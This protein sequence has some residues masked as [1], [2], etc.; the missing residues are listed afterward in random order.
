VRIDLWLWAV[1]LFPTRTASTAACRAGRVQLDGRTVKP[2]ATVG[3]GDRI[4]AVTPGGER[5]VEV[6]R[7]LRRRVGAAIA[8]ECYI[9]HTP[10]APP[11]IVD[12][13]GRRDR[14]SGRPTKRERRDIDR[15]RGR[16][17]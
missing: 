16:R 15:L 17:P 9:D 5:D 3:P 12:T 10:P 4:R 14:G 13:N 7:D 1:R 11:R 2:A 6:V 8:V